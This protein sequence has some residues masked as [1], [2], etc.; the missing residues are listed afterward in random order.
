MAD[1]DGRAW[2]DPRHHALCRSLAED[3]YDPA[4]RRA[5]KGRPQVPVTELALEDLSEAT[6][7]H[8][9]SKIA[10]M[11]ETFEPS[12]TRPTTAA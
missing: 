10:Q 11:M 3:H 1:P 6:L 12:V 4:Y 7:K 5:Q 2:R 9:A 8:A